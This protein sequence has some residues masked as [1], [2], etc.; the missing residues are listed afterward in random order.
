MSLNLN[1][2]ALVS[3]F[4]VIE[5]ESR[6]PKMQYCNNIYLQWEIITKLCGRRD[7]GYDN[8]A[9]SDG[10]GREG[11]N[12]SMKGLDIRKTHLTLEREEQ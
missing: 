9:D 2:L 3:A 1:I 4:C 10:K 5:E 12:L 6:K 7:T 11:N 8:Q